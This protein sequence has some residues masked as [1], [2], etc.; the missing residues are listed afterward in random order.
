M[1]CDSR[2]MDLTSGYVALSMLVL[3]LT[4]EVQGGAL[5][6]TPVKDHHRCGERSG[7]CYSCLRS[8]QSS[9][10]LVCVHHHSYTMPCSQP[11]QECRVLAPCRI[12]CQQDSLNT[13][14]QGLSPPPSPPV[15]TSPAP[16]V[17]TAVPTAPT[18]HEG[19][20]TITFIQIFSPNFGLILG[21]LLRR[22]PSVKPTLNVFSPLTLKTVV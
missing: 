11:G 18:G 20:P 13:S 14:Y 16:T 15:P 6:W 22:L 9:L 10:V 21:Q 19:K 12:T 3:L 2:G 8:G 1:C 17:T 7:I 4:W 5:R